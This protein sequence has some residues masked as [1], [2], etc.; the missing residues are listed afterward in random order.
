GN[1]ELL[2][3]TRPDIIAQIHRDYLEAGADILETNTYNAQRISMADYGMEEL[4][5][6]LN[7]ASA[8]IARDQAD[9]VTAMNPAKPRFVAGAIG[10]TNKTASISPDVNN[11][12]Y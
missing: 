3:L 5:Y 7:V 9:Q 1:N 11:P 8:R 2:S 4:S 10:P 12:G 6:E